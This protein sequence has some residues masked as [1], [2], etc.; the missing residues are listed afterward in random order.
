[1]TSN[2]LVSRAGHSA[3]FVCCDPPREV[4]A[5]GIVEGFRQSR[6]PDVPA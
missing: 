6:L 1:M 4:A 3:A 2:A 5:L